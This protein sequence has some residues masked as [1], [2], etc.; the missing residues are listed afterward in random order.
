MD[1]PP[2]QN[3]FEKFENILENSFPLQPLHPRAL[4]DAEVRYSAEM[5]NAIR[6][7]TIPIVFSDVLE[8]TLQNVEQIMFEMGDKLVM[9]QKIVRQIDRLILTVHSGKDEKKINT[10]I[11]ELYEYLAKLSSTVLALVNN[12]LVNC[13]SFK[14]FL[15][16]LDYLLSKDPE[17]EFNKMLRFLNSNKIL[18]PPQTSL[19]MYLI[20]VVPVD[21]SGIYASK[22]DQDLINTLQ[23]RITFCIALTNSLKE[24][25]KI[26]KGYKNYAISGSE[27]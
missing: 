5:L 10:T 23:S 17:G 18:I 4:L 19:A 20:K 24:I 3:K 2:K 11:A 14:E 21:I 15:E 13:D 7:A 9:Q 26:L 8:K 27:Q 12:L 16:L 22:T 6:Y 1:K 25:R